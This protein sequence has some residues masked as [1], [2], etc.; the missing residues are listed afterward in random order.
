MLTI[1]TEARGAAHSCVYRFRGPGNVILLTLLFMAIGLSSSVD[2]NS[3][4][5]YSPNAEQEYS[6]QILN[7]EQQIKGLRNTDPQYLHFSM[8]LAKLYQTTGDLNSAER[9]L[10]TI[11]LDVPQLTAVDR[12][13]SLRQLGIIYFSQR[14]YQ[15]SYTTFEQTLTLMLEHGDKEY[16]ALGYNDLAN[17]YRAYGDLDTAA[18]LLLESYDLHAEVGNHIGRASTLNNLGSL[19]RERGAF[20]E[21][22]VAQRRAYSIY[23]DI[24]QPARAALTL[25]N[26][27]DTFHKNGDAHKAVELLQESAAALQVQN[28]YHS[29]AKVY[30]LLAEVFVSMDKTNEAQAHLNK[31]RLTWNLLQ[32]T[33]SNPKYWYVQGKVW[34]KL[35]DFSKAEEAYKKAKQDIKSEN[36]FNFQIDLYQTMAKL[37]EKQHDFKQASHNWHLYASTLANQQA[38][39]NSI[40]THQLRSSFTFSSTENPPVHW[41]GRGLIA[42]ACAMVS[43]FLLWGL[44]KI[45]N[46]LK[47]KSNVTATQISSISESAEKNR[48]SGFTD[49]ALNRKTENLAAGSSTSHVPNSLVDIQ[50]T[51]F[52][53]PSAALKNVRGI[54]PVAS[55][56]VDISRY[57]RKDKL[58]SGGN[59]EKDVARKDEANISNAHKSVYQSEKY[60]QQLVE[61]MHL[62]LQMWEEHTQTGKLELAE[63]S[64]VWSVGVDDGRLRARAMERYFSINT[65][66]QKPR[67]RSVVRTCNYVLRQ[68]KEKSLY[69]DELEGNLKSF[70]AVIKHNATVV[71]RCG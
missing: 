44:M 53:L 57:T 56:V 33:T 29:L 10:K 38:L 13:N 12:I 34:E 59:S 3:S 31:A 52:S 4:C 14:L 27:G 2:A 61:M 62:A 55:D 24:N 17:V 6:Q 11:L 45:K 67:W 70:Q 1:T 49:V 66:P 42:I 39:K 43:L 35:N 64:K 48:E 69:R 36:E 22:I 40:K 51:D 20:D 47:T 65:L 23:Q 16:L 9:I 21:A 19:Y 8:A 28:A 30:V 26:L 15:Q 54:L 25:A 37:A 68:C 50:N 7:C 32:A 5:T 60:R 63:K 58:Q 71:S 41:W 46:E 18:K